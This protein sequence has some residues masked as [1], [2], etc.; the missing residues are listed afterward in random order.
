M[1]MDRS[2]LANETVGLLFVVK[3]ASLSACAQIARTRAARAGVA[4]MFDYFDDAAGLRPTNRGRRTHENRG[5][6]GDE[7]S[8]PCTMGWRTP[9]ARAR[10][11]DFL[12]PDP[13][14]VGP[15]D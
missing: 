14:E 6:F 1:S 3:C 13:A 15:A 9:R 11:I 10:G 12:G 4:Q 5:S 8:G 2:S 7:R